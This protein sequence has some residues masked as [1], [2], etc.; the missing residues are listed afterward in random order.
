MPVIA[1][2]LARWRKMGQAVSNASLHRAQQWSPYWL[3]TRHQCILSP[4][5]KPRQKQTSRCQQ[6]F[7][8]A[9]RGRTYD[10][11]FTKL[12]LH[13]KILKGKH[14]L[15]LALFQANA[16]YICIDMSNY[17]LLLCLL[18]PSLQNSFPR[19]QKRRQ[20]G[21]LSLRGEKCLKRDTHV[22]KCW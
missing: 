22:Y 5:Q 11:V 14:A 18:P 20:A 19:Q 12:G 8:F 10:G 17:V 7:V 1:L 3:Y 16:L 21:V 2:R 15:V 4:S 6:Y 13:P 9:E